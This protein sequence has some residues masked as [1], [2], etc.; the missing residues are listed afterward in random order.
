MHVAPT[1]VGEPLFE[2][3]L[4]TQNLIFLPPSPFAPH[5]LSLPLQ[6]RRPSSQRRERVSPPDLLPGLVSGYGTGSM[7]MNGRS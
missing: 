5:F 1:S 4:I 2:T 7:Q 6:G 3:L